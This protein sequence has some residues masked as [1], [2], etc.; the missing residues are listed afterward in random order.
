MALHSLSSNSNIH[1][2]GKGDTNNEKADLTGSI[3]WLRSEDT[4]RKWQRVSCINGEM[5]YAL[6]P[7]TLFQL[8]GVNVSLCKETFIFYTWSL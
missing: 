2:D 7:A 4:R 6:C 3:C 5:L 8:N 1:T